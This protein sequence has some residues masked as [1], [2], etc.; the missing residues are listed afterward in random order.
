MAGTVTAT[1][2][3]S[4]TNGLAMLVKVVTG[5]NASPIGVHPAATN[6]TP[7]LATGTGVTTGSWV[8]G[9]N[10]GLPGTY[11]VNGSTTYEQNFAGSGVQGVSMRTTGTM[12][13]GASV[14][15][16]GTATVNSI[17]IALLELLAGSG[18]AEDG[19]SPAGVTSNSVITLTTASFTPPT[20]SLLVAMVQSNGAGGVT[21]M[22]VTDTGLGL[23]WTEQ[24]KQNGAGNGYAGIWTAPVPVPVV[25]AGMLLAAGI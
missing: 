5:Q 25:S 7:S 15:V 20:G 24:V 21:T 13:G 6:T 11:T 18:L 12:T 19:S 23:T 17:S 9:S 4:T 3:G 2:G 10:L 1:E 8:Y 16:G 22:A 14:T